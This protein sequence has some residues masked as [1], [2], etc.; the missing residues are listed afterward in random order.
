VRIS[1]DHWVSVCYEKAYGPC[2]IERLAA[3]V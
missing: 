3:D 2:L 1:G